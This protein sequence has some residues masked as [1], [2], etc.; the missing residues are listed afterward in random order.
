MDKNNNFDVPKIHSLGIDYKKSELIK[1]II[2]NEGLDCFGENE[3]FYYWTCKYERTLGDMHRF[4][5]PGPFM[6]EFQGKEYD[7]NSF[8]GVSQFVVDIKGGEEIVEI[9][10]GTPM[11]AKKEFILRYSKKY[12]RVEYHSWAH[13][14]EKNKKSKKH[15]IRHTKLPFFSINEKN[16][17]RIYVNRYT[18]RYISNKNVMFYCGHNKYNS[19]D[20]NF[21]LKLN[22]RLLNLHLDSKIYRS[23]ESF[24]EIN[25]KLNHLPNK[26]LRGCDSFEE[27]LDKITKN[28]PVPKILKSKMSLEDIISLYNLVEYDEVDKI[29]K[30][31]YD[32]HEFLSGDLGF[33]N[34][35]CNY[36]Y[37]RLGITIPNKLTKKFDLS[38]S[39]EKVIH[40]GDVYCHEVADYVRILKMLDKKINLNI[41]SVKRLRA[42]HD[43][44]AR[45]IKAASI[46]DIK[47]KRLYPD[48]KSGGDFVVEKIQDKHRL[49]VESEIQNHCVKTYAS[50]INSGN[51][52]IYSFLDKMDGKRYTLEVQVHKNTETRKQAFILN[53]IKGKFNC[54]PPLETLSRAIA[55]LNAAGVYG[56]KQ[57]ALNGGFVFQNAKG[58]STIQGVDLFG[59]DLPF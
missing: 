38:T 13:S 15:Y 30:F 14:I 48:I 5:K 1:F 39:G 59:E 44:M 36:M 11:H 31:L 49:M 19:S 42:E 23:D 28:R 8:E 4:I 22:R 29:I 46:P 27:V 34:V 52:C 7:I 10:Q 33:F 54:S 47:V 53:Q 43:E 3:H 37:L 17:V 35:I 26:V 24:P 21:F 56:S 55:L 32:Y 40:T 58:S 20:N 50:S 6:Y 25:Q 2:D 57:D 9:F 16:H 51:C 12:N 45:K 18:I 41:R